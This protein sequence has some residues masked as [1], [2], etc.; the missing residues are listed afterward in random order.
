MHI[1]QG[2]NENLISVASVVADYFVFVLRARQVH[3]KA[4]EKN[5]PITCNCLSEVDAM[6]MLLRNM[7]H[8]LDQQHRERAQSIVDLKFNLGEPYQ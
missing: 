4:L 8:N 6:L 3:A 2:Y 1:T 5:K 7:Q